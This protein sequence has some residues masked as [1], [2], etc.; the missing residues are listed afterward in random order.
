MYHITFLKEHIHQSCDLV[1]F[2]VFLYSRNE[3]NTD[4]HKGSIKAESERFRSDPLN[5][6]VNAGVGMWQSQMNCDRKAVRGTFLILPRAAF[7]LSFWL[8]VNGRR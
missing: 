6:L 1:V 8:S 5:L 2:F 3:L 7:L 4:D